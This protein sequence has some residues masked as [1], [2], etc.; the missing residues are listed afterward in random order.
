MKRY[1]CHTDYM[2]EDY[3]DDDNRELT[4]VFK[5]EIL[6]ENDPRLSK[7]LCK[8]YVDANKESLL[9]SNNSHIYNLYRSIT[10]EKE[11]ILLAVLTEHLSRKPG[12]EDLKKVELGESPSHPSV[13][14]V[15]YDGYTLGAIIVSDVIPEPHGAHASSIKITFDPIRRSF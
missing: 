14:L 12:I 13:T 8:E 4:F 3:V 7:S 15:A 10:K 11:N 5:G 9:I 1:I 6:N 2:T